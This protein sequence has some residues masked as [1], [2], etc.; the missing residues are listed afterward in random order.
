[1]QSSGLPERQ[2]KVRRAPGAAEGI[3][4]HIFPFRSPGSFGRRRVG[5]TGED[6]AHGTCGRDSGGSGHSWA[7]GDSGCRL[8]RLYSRTSR[9]QVGNN[10]S[11][12]RRDVVVSVFLV[13][14]FPLQGLRVHERRDVVGADPRRAALPSPVRLQRLLYGFR[15]RVQLVRGRVVVAGKAVSPLANL[16]RRGQ[17]LERHADG[18]RCESAALGAQL[19]LWHRVTAAGTAGRQGGPLDLPSDSVESVHGRGVCAVSSR[20]DLL[21]LI[22]DV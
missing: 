5:V 7:A 13:P 10:H 8:R 18:P 17:A 15:D 14:G 2:R 12:P 11:S 19:D 6:S 22:Q 9:A 20:L 1:M 4:S 3:T 16:G 21:D